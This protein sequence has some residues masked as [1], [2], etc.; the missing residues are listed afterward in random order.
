M[1]E[2]RLAVLDDLDVVLGDCGDFVSVAHQQAREPAGKAVAA[3]RD[4]HHEAAQSLVAAA[5][6]LLLHEVLGFPQLGAAYKQ[7]SARDIEET[8]IRLLRITVIELATAR[9][10]SNT[11][12]HEIG[13]N[14]HGTLHGE[15]EFFSPAD[16]LSGLLLL[17]AWVRELAWWQSRHPEGIGRL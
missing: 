12:Q 16:C 13:F 11:D 7:L 1:V 6:G 4:G 9:A 15:P 8:V 10:L 17:G 3:E 2:R 14:R 5:L